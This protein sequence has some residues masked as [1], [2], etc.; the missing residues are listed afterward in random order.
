[1][2]LLVT[3]CSRH[4]LTVAKFL[5]YNLAFA[6]LSLGMGIL[7]HGVQRKRLPL[8]LLYD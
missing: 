2:V 7:T 8:I 5:M 1:M 3:M 6:D 4:K